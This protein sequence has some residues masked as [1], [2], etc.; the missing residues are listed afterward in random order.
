MADGW[1]LKLTV[2]FVA[3]THEPLH[4]DK[5]SF[6]HWKTIDI[7]TSSVWII[8]FLDGA[9]EYADDAK[10]WGY[11]GTNAEPLCRIL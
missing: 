7:T 9:F 6:V 10:L 1:N 8:I 5:W 2:C 4:L 3:T 11:A